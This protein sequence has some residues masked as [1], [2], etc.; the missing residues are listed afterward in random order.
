MIST[1]HTQML[2]VL[3]SRVKH[4]S[5]Y[6]WQTIYHS[7]LST[8]PISLSSNSFSQGYTHQ[9]KENGSLIVQYANSNTETKPGW[10]K[11]FRMLGL[12]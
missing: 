10:T 5:N 9:Q 11:H 2:I 8:Q 12:S 7:S 3:V 4:K 6:K 1:L